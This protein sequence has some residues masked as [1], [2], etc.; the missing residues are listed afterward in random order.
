MVTLVEKKLKKTFH[1]SLNPKIK[2]W[3]IGIY[4]LGAGLYLLSVYSG[5]QW[6]Y[7]AQFLKSLFY[8]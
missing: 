1:H 4:F 7:T 3:L 6:K 5:G 8:E 2:D